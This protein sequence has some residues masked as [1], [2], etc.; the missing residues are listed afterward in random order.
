MMT[1]M[2]RTEIRKMRTRTKK[3]LR[4]QMRTM[5]MSERKTKKIRR[6][7]MMRKRKKKPNQS[8][9]GEEAR[10]KMDVLLTKSKDL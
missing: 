4:N 8:P 5:K 7:L 9:V 3:E 10:S 1:K 2:K 6:T